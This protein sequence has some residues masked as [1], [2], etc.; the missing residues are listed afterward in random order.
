MQGWHDVRGK[1]SRR[2]QRPWRGAEDANGVFR[3]LR[4]ATRSPDAGLSRGCVCTAANAR[5]VGGHVGSVGSRDNGRQI[6]C[7]RPVGVCAI[8]VGAYGCRQRQ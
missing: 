1:R 7:G 8:D 6:H 2:V 3:E 5:P 4:G